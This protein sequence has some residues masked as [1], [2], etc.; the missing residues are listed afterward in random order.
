MAGAVINCKKCNKIFQQRLHPICPE[1]VKIEEEQFTL[2]YRQLQ[3]SA[4]SGGIDIDVLADNSGI[5]QEDIEKFYLEG[6]LSTAGL[7]LRMPCQACGAMCGEQD[8]KGRFC[9]TCSEVTANKA[10]VEVKPLQ[11]IRKEEELTQQRE[12]QGA[13]LKQNIQNAQGAARREQ[14]FGSFIRR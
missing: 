11:E 10:G 13:L 3:A 9:N 8:R 7:Y 1:C 2:L 14:Q 12:A 5:T 6:R 4:A